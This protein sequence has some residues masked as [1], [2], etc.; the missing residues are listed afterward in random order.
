MQYDKSELYKM[1]DLMLGLCGR[2]LD[3]YKG[4]TQVI[5]NANFNYRQRKGLVWRPV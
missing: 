2:K 3:G 4:N 5:Y 1:L